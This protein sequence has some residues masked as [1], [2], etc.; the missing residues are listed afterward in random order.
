MKLENRIEAY[1][2]NMITIH[3]D[4][5]TNAYIQ[6]YRQY[7]MYRYWPEILKKQHN[8]FAV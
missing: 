3:A 7:F 1:A 6:K 4:M 5:Y 8:T 2:V